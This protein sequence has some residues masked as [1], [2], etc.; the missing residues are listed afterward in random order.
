MASVESPG[1]EA[2]AHDEL[3]SFQSVVFVIHAGSQD[4]NDVEKGF[5]PGELLPWFHQQAIRPDLPPKQGVASTHLTPIQKNSLQQRPYLGAKQ[6][7]H[8]RFCI[9]S[10][11]L[12]A[13]FSAISTKQVQ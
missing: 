10:N 7:F 2:D 1:Q 6:A 9:G 8:R 5:E 13:V 12:Q 3:S 11:F 4:V